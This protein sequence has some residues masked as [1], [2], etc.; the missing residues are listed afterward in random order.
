MLW[1]H[2]AEVIIE[3]RSQIEAVLSAGALEIIF[4]FLF[5]VF[6]FNYCT[7]TNTYMHTY[8]YTHTH[9]HTHIPYHLSD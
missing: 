7:H 6:H 4:S 5:K 1:K 2:P 3:I 8:I 9:I